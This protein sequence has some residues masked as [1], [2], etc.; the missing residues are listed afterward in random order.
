MWCRLTYLLLA[1]K[2]IP[3][4]KDVVDYVDEYC[5]SGFYVLLR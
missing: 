3:S 5:A 4:K 2:T 1:R